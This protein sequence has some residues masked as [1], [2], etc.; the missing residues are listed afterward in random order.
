V[1]DY[2]QAHREQ[3]I[4]APRWARPGEVRWDLCRIIAGNSG[5]DWTI[6]YVGQ[7]LP[8][9]AAASAAATTISTSSVTNDT[10]RPVMKTT[11][12]GTQGMGGY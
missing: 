8:L 10:P 12:I 3:L 7:V 9:M 4:Q 5:N 11:G 1:I 6:E 2:K